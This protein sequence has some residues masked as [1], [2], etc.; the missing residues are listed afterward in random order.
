MANQNDQVSRLEMIGQ[1]V[2]EYREALPPDQPAWREVIAKVYAQALRDTDQVSDIAL[3][4]EFAELRNIAS[5]GDFE[6]NAAAVTSSIVQP[7]MDSAQNT[8]NAVKNRLPNPALEMPL[9][10]SATVV[11]LVENPGRNLERTQQ[12]AAMV[13]GMLNNAWQFGASKLGLPTDEERNRLAEIYELPYEERLKKLHAETLHDTATMVSIGSAPGLFAGKINSARATLGSAAQTTFSD[14]S[15]L[16]AQAGE[17]KPALV[18][19]PVDVGSQHMPAV[20]ASKAAAV[21]P[22]AQPSSAPIMINGE[23]SLGTS[24]LAG[25]S[26]L[27]Q[28]NLP[29]ITLEIGNGL[30]HQIAVRLHIRPEQMVDAATGKPRDFKG[31][32]EALLPMLIEKTKP[33]NMIHKLQA[34]EKVDVYF[35]GHPKQAETY[36][37]PNHKLGE[38]RLTVVVHSHNSTFKNYSGTPVYAYVYPDANIRREGDRFFNP[39][40]PQQT[41]TVTYGARH[42]LST[43]V[44]VLDEERARLQ[45]MQ[46]SLQKN[47]QTAE[48]RRL[49]S[50]LTF[51]TERLE[52]I[53]QH[54]RESTKGYPDGARQRPV[55][56]SSAKET[57]I[58][59]TEAIASVATQDRRSRKPLIPSAANT[60]LKTVLLHQQDG[61]PITLTYP[62]EMD[63]PGYPRIAVTSNGLDL[64]P[65]KNKINELPR[66]AL[67]QEIVDFVHDHGGPGRN[68]PGV[69]R[70]MSQAARE[71]VGE[72]NVIYLGTRN[73][74]DVDLWKYAYGHTVTDNRLVVTAQMKGNDGNLIK[75]VT[76]LC[77]LHQDGTWLYNRLSDSGKINPSEKP[78]FITGNRHSVEKIQDR[79][80]GELEIL[81]KNAKLYSGGDISRP[82]AEYDIKSLSPNSKQQA[83]HAQ[84]HDE[85]S[86][87]LNQFLEIAER[88]R[89]PVSEKAQTAA[90]ATSGV[91]SQASE[92]MHPMDGQ[93]CDAQDAFTRR[94]IEN[95]AKQQTAADCSADR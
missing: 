58:N 45:A 25:K 55:A 13:G 75:P 84:R 70:S 16:T 27:N 32:S 34:V 94:I 89:A 2:K 93:G 8:K 56:D 71:S 9:S 83:L 30:E 19:G 72:I 73:Q 3:K 67:A 50:D 39:Q 24:P 76:F 29:P 14:L 85:I 57:N 59:K 20:M 87:A 52:Q 36:R 46:T 11:D 40:S 41:L 78:F 37:N 31:L 33:E 6:T 42:N 60:D 23:Q 66:Q 15:R 92:K 51:Q 95:A 49:L 68:G 26:T 7:M 54:I 1:L 81:A 18:T 5:S 65:A 62:A 64:L 74:R 47:L 61:V 28:V 79:L 48:D 38:E 43:G 53:A 12:A 21:L 4:E 22:A 80:T 10:M 86:A 17:L 82:Q 88:Y 63:K 91:A 69:N 44:T 90:V 35:T 77:N